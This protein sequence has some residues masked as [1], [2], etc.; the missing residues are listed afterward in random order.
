[1]KKPVFMI[2]PNPGETK[3]HFKARLI[4]L[5][6]K[7]QPLTETPKPSDKSENSNENLRDRSSKHTPSN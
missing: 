5:L 7:E 3:E 4:A 2:K 1:M 6:K